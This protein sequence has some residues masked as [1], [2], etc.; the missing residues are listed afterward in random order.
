MENNYATAT[1]KR[2]AMGNKVRVLVLSGG[3]FV[4]QG[5]F[6]A[7]QSSDW[8]EPLYACPGTEPPPTA[9]ALV[10]TYDENDPATLQRLLAQADAVVNCTSNPG[11]RIIAVAQAVA[12]HARQHQ[13]R[14]V[15]ISS[16][17]AYGGVQGRI[18]EQHPLAPA[19]EL[20]D[21]AQGKARSDEIIA[22]V[23]NAVILREGLVY[24]PGSEY[25]GGL[26]GRLLV[27]GRLG[28][29][30]AQGEG[31]CN[32]IHIDD[33]VEVVLQALRSQDT[34]TA[35]FNLVAPGAPSWNEFLLAYA[36][37]LGCTHVPA[38]S[39]A[40]LQLEARAFSVILRILAKLAARLSL[41]AG[42]LPDPIRQSL[43]RS[44]SQKIH[45]DTDK[46]TATYHVQW[47]TLQHGLAQMAQWFHQQT[48]GREGTSH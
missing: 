29:L 31:V 9:G 16:L 11:V 12:E 47:H 39:A 42:S 25:W 15:Q 27:S 7:L 35:I 5:I 2:A 40:R 26:I 19:H 28:N 30:G 3:N 14:V 10:A 32:L 20:D 48:P 36:K 37:A 38:I 18:D 33:L 34:G 46:L 21:Y 1:G 44:F 13:L 45:A 43:L 4:S 23:S 24:G 8:A 41:P 6:A 17:S 22:R